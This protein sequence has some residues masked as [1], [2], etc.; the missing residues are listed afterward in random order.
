MAIRPRLLA[1]ADGLIIRNSVSSCSIPWSSV[2]KF[3]A[4]DKGLAVVTTDYSL[5]RVDAVSAP[6]TTTSQRQYQVAKTLESL[7]RSCEYAIP[8]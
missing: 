2:L 4:T 8:D 6:G 7:R 3:V 5:A 1:D